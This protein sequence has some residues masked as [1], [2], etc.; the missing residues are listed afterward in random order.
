[1]Y[2]GKD[3][4]I[5]AKETISLKCK[6]FILEA[7]QT[8]NMKAGTTMDVATTQTCTVDGGLQLTLT[9]AMTNIN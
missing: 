5:E 9:A 3:I 1:M 7:D 4:I 2:S 6:D 8:I